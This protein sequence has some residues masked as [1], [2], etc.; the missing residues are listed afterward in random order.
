[1][2][3]KKMP[4]IEGFNRMPNGVN[5]DTEWKGKWCER[6]GNDHPIVLEIGCGKGDLAL[7]LAHLHPDKNFIGVDIKGVRLYSGARRALTEELHNVQFLRCDIHGIGLFFAPQ[8]ISEIWITFPDPFPKKGQ[9]RNRL[10]NEIFLAQYARIL[11]PG[12]KLYLKTDNTSLFAYTLDHL[13]EL[14]QKAVFQVDIYHHVSDLHQSDLTNP[15]NGVITDYE[16][17]FLDMGKPICYLELSLVEGPNLDSVP[18]TE[19]VAL[20][21]DEKAPRG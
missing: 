12:G 11:A 19:K 7:G 3:R 2:S 14:E 18:L 16:R 10:T 17:R 6:F 20:V 8:E 21:T 5:N 4:K 9:T 15:D 1:M 13:A